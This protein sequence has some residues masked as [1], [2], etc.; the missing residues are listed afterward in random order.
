MEGLNDIAT[1][2]APMIVTALGMGTV[3]S[4]LILLYVITRIM[5]SGLSR[6]LNPRES[7]QSAAPAAAGGEAS[8]SEAPEA[9]GAT[10]PAEAGIAAAITLVLARH[11]A[12][13]V[14]P[15]AQ[16]AAGVDP[17]KI[18]GRMRVLRAK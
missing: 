18:A 11:R 8:G 9:M 12:A 7:K 2:G 6:L 10:A 15:V 5:G 13:R 3:F 4:C 17:W 1:T 16:E 14:A